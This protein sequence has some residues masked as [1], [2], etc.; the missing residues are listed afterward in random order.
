[1]G[2]IGVTAVS[3]LARKQLNGWVRKMSICKSMLTPP[4]AF[5]W[6]VVRYICSWTSSF[7][8]LL[9]SGLVYL[10]LDFIVGK[11][12]LLLSDF[13]FCL[14]QTNVKQPGVTLLIFFSQSIKL[15]FINI[16][17]DE[18]FA[19]SHY[20]YPFFILQS[21]QLFIFY[22]LVTTAIQIWDLLTVNWVKTVPFSI[23][24]L[25]IE[26]RAIC[27]S[28]EPN[29]LVRGKVIYQQS[30]I[31]GLAILCGGEYVYLHF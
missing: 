10:I 15:F 5:C 7:P 3:A 22:P 29:T 27:F 4:G 12:K 23:N 20:R 17:N 31:R 11:F 24:F 8:V 30:V 26:I 18:K 25:T 1:M 16:Y 21:S 13:G 9:G 14:V 28:P 19:F 2:L 6:V